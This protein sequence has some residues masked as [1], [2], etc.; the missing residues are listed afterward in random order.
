MA[1]PSPGHPRDPAQAEKAWITGTSPVMTTESGE[2]SFLYTGF[3]EADNRGRNWQ[4]IKRFNVRRRCV[5]S[6]VS[7]TRR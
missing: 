2:E 6:W 7:P 3:S 4:S 5:D 1:G